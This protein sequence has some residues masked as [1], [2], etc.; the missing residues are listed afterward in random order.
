[1]HIK[2]IE[3]RVS[4]KEITRREACGGIGQDIEGVCG[5]WENLA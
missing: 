5:L 2:G 3:H 1:M 4:V